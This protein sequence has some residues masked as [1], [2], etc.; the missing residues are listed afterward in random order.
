MERDFLPFPSSTSL[1][2]NLETPG[3]V[4][5]KILPY[6]PRTIDIIIEGNSRFSLKKSEEKKKEP[7]TAANRQTR[8]SFP[9][10]CQEYL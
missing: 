2:M 5:C 7:E 6:H 9:E 10:I 3:I 8:A 1:L 4:I